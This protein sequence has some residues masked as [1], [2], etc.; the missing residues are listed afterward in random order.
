MGKYDNK[1]LK[2]SKRYLFKA[3][4]EAFERLLF[5]VIPTAQGRLKWLKKHKKIAMIGEHVHFQPRKY[6]T[7]GYM[8]KIHN[9]VAIAT[10]VEFTLHDIIHWVY[11][12]IDGERI[13][14]EYA[15][16][17]E[18]YDN[19]FIGAGSRILPGVT[20]GPNAIVAAGSVVNKDVPEGSIVGGVPAKVI[21]SFDD[22][23]KKRKKYTS[24]IRKCKEKG[25]DVN[26]FL[27]AEFYK[28][29]KPN[30]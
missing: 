25:V 8:L 21:G 23:W 13:N 29:H 26:H 30:D 9:N 5:A 19:V 12:G 2:V 16:C 24:M 3:K 10:D 17:I 14:T 11:D 7:D 22:L 6:P 1:S 27:W 15:G 28:I 20:I 4:I 18:I